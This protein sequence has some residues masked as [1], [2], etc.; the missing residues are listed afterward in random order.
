MKFGRDISFFVAV[1]LCGLILHLL[2]FDQER[3]AG[4]RLER[5]WTER[6]AWMRNQVL[7]L[8][9]TISSKND[10]HFERLF[11]R[12]A[13]LDDFSATNP[14]PCTISIQSAN[15]SRFQLKT[16]WA[17]HVQV[18][19]A[20]QPTV[21]QANFHVEAPRPLTLLPL[22]AFALAL[23]FEVHL[24]PFFAML[25]LYVFL[26]AGANLLQAVRMAG[27]AV[28]H[29]VAVDQT[30]LGL[31]FIAAWLAATKARAQAASAQPKIESKAREWWVNRTLAGLLGLWSP[32][33]FTMFGKALVPLRGGLVHPFLDAQFA[34]TAV[35]LY[36]FTIDWESLRQSVVDTMLLPRYF[37]F[38]VL[39]LF[40]AQ[41]WLSPTRRQ[42]VLWR[43]PHFWR[44]VGAVALVEALK[45]VVPPLTE[46]NS[47][48]RFG[49]ALVVSEL[50]WPKGLPWKPAA[51]SAGPWV[52]V[53]FLGIF[54]TVLSLESGICDLALQLVN[55]RA[56]PRVL[57][58]ATFVGGV[59]MGFLTGSFSS[60]FFTLFAYLQSP[61]VPLL[62]AALLD[63]VLAGLLLSPISLFNLLPAVQFGMS[64][65][66]VLLFRFGQL[67]VPLAIGVMI[68]AVA[69]INSVAI[70]R[71]VT[72]VFCFLAAM[73]YHLRKSDWDI[74]RGT[75]SPA[76]HSGAS[77]A[78]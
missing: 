10:T 45:Y 69:A 27:S 19:S 42:H 68:Y 16:T 3:V 22:L 60:A 13:A 77:S 37:T 67:A 1:L 74:R 63:G 7:S 36:L 47:I 18:A 52:A 39:L 28:W 9:D 55:P 38:A 53:I 56:H 62:R 4:L 72:F 51:K 15:A 17:F 50:A 65:R 54:A 5:Q 24:F 8:C 59:T 58:L 64:V 14:R 26:L 46:L 32:T 76:E 61:H 30:F 6:G 75:F 33:I 29:T 41:T 31:A 21:L 23:L 2:P 40:A 70:L 34:I 11:L 43:I 44:A 71:P 57:Y 48:T 49:L 73:A 35:S 78:G 66:K 25:A 20:T 12:W